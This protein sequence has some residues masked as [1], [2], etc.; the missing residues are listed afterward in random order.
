[1]L[2]KDLRVLLAKLSLKHFGQ[3]TGYA[4]AERDQ[5]KMRSAKISGGIFQIVRERRLYPL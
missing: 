3:R 1:V 2:K 5:I 4:A